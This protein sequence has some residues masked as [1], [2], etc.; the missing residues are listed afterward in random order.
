MDR[1]AYPAAKGSPKGGGFQAAIY[2]NMAPVK[3]G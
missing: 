2:I 3:S 1:S